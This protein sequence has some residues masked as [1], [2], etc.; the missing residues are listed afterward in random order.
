VESASDFQ[1]AI[2]LIAR[3]TIITRTG[4]TGD[5]ITVILNHIRTPIVVRRTRGT[6]GVERIT[7]TTAIITT[8]IKQA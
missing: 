8:A 3:H 6:T 4:I 2:T 5:R 1:A 7:A